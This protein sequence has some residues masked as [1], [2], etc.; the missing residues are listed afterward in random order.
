MP[1]LCSSA[2]VTVRMKTPRFLPLRDVQFTQL[3]VTG[4]QLTPFLLM[5]HHPFKNFYYI[6]IYFIL[7]PI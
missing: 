1:R 5:D 3:R 4:T 2:N 6:L 7:F